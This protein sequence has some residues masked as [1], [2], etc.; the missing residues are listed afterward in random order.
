[1]K[2]DYFREKQDAFSIICREI[3]DKHVPKKSDIYDL[4]ISLSLQ[5][6]NHLRQS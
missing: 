1:M 4:T 6:G 5:E 2:K 3:F